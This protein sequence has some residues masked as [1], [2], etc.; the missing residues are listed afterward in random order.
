MGQHQHQNPEYRDVL[1]AEELIGPHTV[2]TLPPATIISLKDHGQIRA[3]INEGLDEA[4]ALLERLPEL[5]VDYDAAT[6][7]LQDDGVV[8]FANSFVELLETLEIKREAIVSL[9]VSPMTMDLASYQDTHEIR[10]KAWNAANTAARIWEGDG[11]VWVADPDEAAATPELTNRLGWLN[12]P[13]EMM[14]ET[15]DLADFAGEVKAAGFQDVVLLGMGGSSL[16]PEVFMRTFG[17]ADGVPL[18]VLDSTN[19]DQIAAVTAGLS[20]LARTLFLVS[21]KSGGT[22]EMLSL[23]KYFYDLVGSEKEN[24]GENFVAITDAGSG[25]ETLG[26][27]KGFRRIFQANPEVGG[28]YSALTHFGLVPAALIGVNIPRLCAGP[29]AWPT[30]AAAMP[31]TIQAYS[32]GRP[33]ANWPW[34]VRDKITFFTSP[35][36]AAFGTWVEQ[37]IAESL[38]KQGTGILPV[39]DEAV[40]EPI[41]YGN[42]RYFVYLRL[43]GD[44]NVE[45]DGKVEVLEAAGH[46]VIWIEM[47]GVGGSG[48]GILP[49][50]DGNRHRR[51]C[52]KDQPL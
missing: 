46:P 19:P 3:S 12:L 2:D 52:F 30:L 1:Y 47:D 40:T 23:Y 44:N 49:L 28:R 13:A 37:L 25:L 38:G 36:I 20:D 11:T 14:A 17:A 31:C 6:Q 5:G 35:K 22:I 50:G 45:L 32:S 9:H 27:E 10:I 15:E 43:A 41:L 7:K 33:W 48:A 39:V 34:P 16:A 51:R 42:D 8:A 18:T 26:R 4:P 21:S 29:A 24:P